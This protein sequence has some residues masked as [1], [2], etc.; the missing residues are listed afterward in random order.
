MANKNPESHYDLNKLH[1]IFAILTLVLLASLGGLFL[2]DYSRKW[3]DYQKDFQDLE[4]EKAR[5]KQ[6]LESNKLKNNP[7]YQTL[8]ADLEKAKKEFA[9]QCSNLK[10]LEQELEKLATE[11]NLLSQRL[12]FVRAELDASRYRYEE[13]MAHHSH[14]LEHAKNEFE[15]LQKQSNELSAQLEKSDLAVKEKNKALGDCSSQ[16]KELERKER[17]SKKYVDLYERKLKKIDPNEMNFMNRMAQLIRNFPIIDLSNPSYKI[18]Q[19]VLKDIT[20]DV[21]FKQVPRIDRC[22][23]CHLGIANPDYKDAPQP[24][25][26]HPNLELYVG[27]NSPHPMEEF[28]CTTCHAGRGRATDFVSAVH[29]PSS[30]EQE[31]EWKEKYGWY[32]YHHWEEPMFPLIYTEAGCLKCHS[33][34]T[35]I[36]GAEKLNLGLNLIER[37]GCYN[38]HTIKKY[39]G[40]PKSGP[41]LNKL[42]SKVSKEWAYKWISNPHSFRHN[43]W[44]PEFF[45]QS[46]NNDLQAKKRVEQEI[47]AMVHFLFKQSQEYKIETLPMDGDSHGGEKLVASLGCYACHQIQQ[48]K[49]STTPATRDTLRR[50]HGPNLIGLGSKT[51][52]EWLYNWLKDPNRY[53]PETKM[54]NLRL[55]DQE[56][57]DIAAFLSQDKNNEF[58]SQVIPPISEKIVNEI[59]F[60]FL[61]KMEPST[62]AQQKL[63][64][65]TL[66][67]KLRF[68]G[69]KL[70]G[71]YGCYACHNISGFENA[72]PIGVEL[73]E[74]GS[75]AIDKL[76]FGFIHIEHSRHGWFKQKLKDPRIFDKDKIKT[77]YEKLKMPNFQLTDEKAEA[78]VTALLGFTK[79]VTVTNKKKPRTPEN[80]YIE[81]GQKLIRQLNCQGCHIMEGEGGAIQESVKDWLIKF[82][83]RDES[84][85]KGLV[86][87][88]SPPNLV[89]EGKK[90]HAKWLFDFLHEPTAIRPWLKVRMPTYSFNAA[91]LNALVKYF[92]ALDKEEFPFPESTDTS[93]TEEELAQAEKLFSTE[94]FGCA[95]CHI[96]GDKMPSGSPDSWAPNFAL[97]KSRLKP[98]WIIEWLKNPSALLPGTKMPAYFDPANFDKSGPEDIMGGEEN[99]QIRILRNYLLRLAD[100][101]P[102]MPTPSEPPASPAPAENLSP[103]E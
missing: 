35:V 33:N 73:T 8:L 71:H 70:I 12:K 3:K 17:S 98:E 29:T 77:H 67:E 6:D 54:P 49:T 19:I 102:V 14:E 64:S 85:A 55:S 31:K 9:S 65:L 28:G 2:K 66:D 91:H 24:L 75:K 52:K 74:E 103:T 93:L 90:V 60:D 26:T 51:S 48:E 42:S 30:L 46:N 89:G 43:T 27:N 41:D 53:H 50:E 34:Q 96:V 72:K 99:E 100:H 88:F 11:N 69:E 16:V 4:I 68:T 44:M 97:A 84:E 7:E 87:S 13:A 61:S 37:A 95:Q 56:A 15:G 57:A 21:N 76:D 82:D 10:S 86:T 92:N 23:T 83:N 94:Y 59:T 36:K 63:A 32:H 62:V 101:S 22:I 25:R 47:H 80:L 20:D 1:F 5:V 58:D 40:W 78:I 45:N 81:E 38:C 39:E 79:D 18:E